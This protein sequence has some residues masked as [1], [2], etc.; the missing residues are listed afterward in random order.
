MSS[1]AQPT[2]ETIGAILARGLWRKSVVSVI[3]L[4]AVWNL[5]TSS[6]RVGAFLEG[7]GLL[8][9]TANDIRQVNVR[10][11]LRLYQWLLSLR[12]TPREPK[13]VSLVFLDDIV[14]WSILYGDLPTD[15]RYLAQLI[16]HA[17]E[18]NTKASVVALDIELDAPLGYPAGMDEQDAK[19]TQQNQ[20]LLDA[21][22][23]A[24]DHG[25]R[26][27]LP[28]GYVHKDGRKIQLP[29]IYRDDQ[30]PL[31][32]PDGSCKHAA[33]VSFGFTN[34]PEDRREI[35]LVQHVF[36][37]D[38]SGPSALP[39]F[40]LAIAD[41]NDKGLQTTRRNRAIAHAIENEKPIYGSFMTE[42]AFPRIDAN[43]L[44]RGVPQAEAQCQDRIVL[45]GGR[46]HDLHGY[47]ALTDGHFSPAG[48]ISG[49]AFHANYVE[50]L[51]FDGF[52]REVPLWLAVILDIFV[53]LTIYSVFGVIHAPAASPKKSRVAVIAVAIILASL[54]PVSA[55]YVALVS[56]NRY[57]DFLLPVELYFLHVLYELIRDYV[58][59]K[60][61]KTVSMVGP[62]GSDAIVAHK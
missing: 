50:S 10:L 24:A 6:T 3:L 14:H 28:G 52:S 13:R 39:S 57:L 25:V 44:A 54:L 42:N 62:I 56:F 34:A 29:R 33:C 45:I 40:A 5:L 23:W 1:P 7:P 11:Q 20:A 47:G 37:W 21:L 31:P 12:A 41:A 36:A 38:G 16:R 60:L 15:R 22:F 8:K 55:A 43:D 27:V 19:R 18:P 4:V 59:A 49:L 35:P 48:M 9:S 17:A 58:H 61:H 26:V 46:W 30:L 32:G 2:A 53:G 51:L